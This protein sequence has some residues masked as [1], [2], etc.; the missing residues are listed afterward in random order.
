MGMGKQPEDIPIE[1]PMFRA[2][3]VQYEQAI[4]A[5][6]E[7]LGLELDEIRHSVE[8]GTVDHDVEVACGTLPAGSVVGQIMSWSGYRDGEP[9]LV[10]QE[11]WTVTDI[12]GWDLD[13]AQTFLVR[14]IVEGAP[15][16]QPR[17]D[18]RQRAGRRARGHVGWTARGGDDRGARAAGCARR[19]AGRRDGARVR[20]VPLANLTAFPIL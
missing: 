6:A 9:V 10:A 8:T 14:V 16:L 7:V 3:S 18:H 15:T 17:A 2:V 11:Y 12:P 13:L 1:S 20:R 19:A 5:A 4:G